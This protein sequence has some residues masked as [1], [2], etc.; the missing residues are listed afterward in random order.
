MYY[1][2]RLANATTQAEDWLSNFVFEQGALGM[3]EQLQY[4]PK[5]NTDEVQTLAQSHH[6][7]EIYFESCPELK[8]FE[9]IK[10]RYP[11]ISIEQD[12]REEEDWM[13]GWKKN[14]SSFELIDGVWVVPSWLEAPKKA[15][16]L[17]HV[18]PGMAF[19]T[20]TH[21]TTSMMASCL[22]WISKQSNQ[23]EN[24]IDVG[25]GTGILAIL[26]SLLGYKSLSA[27]DT[28]VEAQRVSKEN[29]ERNK[30][31][32]LMSSKQLESFSETFDVVLA[33]IIQGVLVLIQKDLVQRVK[34]GGHLV[35]SGILKVDEDEFRKDFHL[36]EDMKWV[37]R[38]EDGEWIALIAQRDLV[39]CH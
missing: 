15:K 22:S 3:S 38:V 23:R 7:L 20:G 21:E 4:A 12:S 35:V 30:V 29:F 5:P 28:D 34:P 2:V 13:E 26:A 18:D 19:G 27:T 10:T 33:N 37:L 31:K 14:F 1:V 36:D 39:T 9:E 6:V 25:T 16:H 11:E 24:L 8:F 32:V 17:I